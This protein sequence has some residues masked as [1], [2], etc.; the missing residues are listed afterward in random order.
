MKRTTVMLDEG[1]YSEL[2]SYARRDGVSRVGSSARPWSCTSSGATR[3]GAPNP[4]PSFVGAIDDPDIQGTDVED[5]LAPGCLFM[6][7]SGTDPGR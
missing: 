2:E 6:R 1:V 4:L 5:F 7:P 3:S